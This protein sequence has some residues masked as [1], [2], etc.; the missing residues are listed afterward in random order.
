MMKFNFDSVFKEMM[1]S[2]DLDTVVILGHLNPDGDAVVT[3]GKKRYDT[4][5]EAILRD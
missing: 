5:D 4:N 3:N 2:H 1:K